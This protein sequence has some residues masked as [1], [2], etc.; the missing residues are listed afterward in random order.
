MVYPLSGFGIPVEMGA[1]MAV[2][3]SFHSEKVFD[4]PSEGEARAIDR[5]NQRNRHRFPSSA[6]VFTNTKR[7]HRLRL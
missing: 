7:N 3:L 2:P 6:A 5:R 4:G 1:I